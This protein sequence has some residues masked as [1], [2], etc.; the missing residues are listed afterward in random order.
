LKKVK[1]YASLIPSGSKLGKLH[2]LAKVH[3]DGV[4]LRTI[5]SMVGTPEY[6]LANIDNLKKVLALPDSKQR[7]ENQ[8]TI[9]PYGIMSWIKLLRKSN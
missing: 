8:I 2:G 4:P 9:V 6:N 7:D 3:K 1:D 5:V